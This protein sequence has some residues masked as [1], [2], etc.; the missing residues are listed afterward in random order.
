MDNAAALWPDKPYALKKTSAGYL[1]ASFAEVRGEARA[2]AAWLVGQGFAPGDRAAL[3]GEGCP[4]WIKAEFGVFYAGLV[5]V[6]LS[7]KLTPDEL[8][9]RFE[10]S[11]AR[12]FLTTRAQLEKAAAAAARRQGEAP[13]FVLL[14]EEDAPDREEERPPASGGA[15]PSVPREARPLAPPSSLVSLAAAVAAGRTA[16]DDPSG[17]AAARLSELDASRRETDLAVISYTS[18]TMGN[19][20]GVMLSH[21]NFWTNS[22]DLSQSFN[23]SPKDRVLLFLPI[24]HAFIHT[25]AIFTALW[26]GVALYF[27]DARGGGMAMLKNIPLNI[28]ECQPTILF[29]VPAFSASLMKRIAAGVR[30]RGPAAAGLFGAGIAAAEKWMRPER[31]Q[32]ALADRIKAALP[33]FFAKI[34]LFGV[35]RKKAVGAALRF[36]ISGSS[37]LEPRQQKFF[38]ALGIPLLPGYGLTEAGPVVS[39]NTLSRYKFGTVGPP[40]PSVRLSVLDAA[41]KSLPQGRLGEVAVSGDSVMAGYYRNPEASEAALR[42]GWLKTG[43]LGFM[44]SEGFLSVVGRESALLVSDSGNKYSPETIEEAVMSSARFFQQV[45]VWCLYKKYPCAL[46]ALDMAETGEFVRENGTSGAEELCRALREDFYRF[47]AGPGREAIQPA[48]VPVT[49]Q[50]VGEGFGEKDGTLNSTMKLVRRRIETEHRELIDYS[51]TKEGAAVVNPRNIAV[52]RRL[53]DLRV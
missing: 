31:G 45:V 50:I 17:R 7:P 13:V 34:F 32:A 35:V 46:V 49:F 1:A 38:A 24:D 15:R 42:D 3:L 48:W 36:C 39:A 41:G 20:K 26:G 53:F 44:D 27:A 40:L 9:F 28:R 11:R 16:L 37:R 29:T 19:P 18:G 43:D 52:L 14:D 6:P 12:L 4:E 22:R 33:Y 5:S 30:Q 10:H 25:T 51:Y 47:K 2:F 21:L 8:A 23:I